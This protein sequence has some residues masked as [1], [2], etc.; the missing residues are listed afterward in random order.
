MHKEYLGDGAYVDFYGNV[1][2]VTTEDGID[3]QNTIVLEPEV[4][5]MLWRYAQRAWPEL[6]AIHPEKAEVN[7]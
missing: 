5:V 3:V 4:F 1:L 6:S 7:Q 2:T